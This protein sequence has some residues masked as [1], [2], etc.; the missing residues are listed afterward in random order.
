MIG[1][2]WKKLTDGQSN[3]LFSNQAHALDGTIDG[4]IFPWLRDTRAFVLNFFM[5]INI[6]DK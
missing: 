4:A 6:I 1:Q 2:W 5:Y 3:P